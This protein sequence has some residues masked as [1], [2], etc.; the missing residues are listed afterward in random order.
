MSKEMVAM[1]NEA[2]RPWMAIVSDVILLKGRSP[3]VAGR[4]V[5]ML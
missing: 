1:K 2:T 4:G 3:A 5:R